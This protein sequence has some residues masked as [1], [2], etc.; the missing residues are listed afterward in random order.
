MEAPFF[1]TVTQTVG[2]TDGHTDVSQWYLLH[3]SA[4]QS[5]T[6]DQGEFTEMAWFTFDEIRQ[7]QPT[8]FDPHLQRFTGKLAMFLDQ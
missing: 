7:S 1:V 4:A 2:L 3:G 6:F 8:I 5:L